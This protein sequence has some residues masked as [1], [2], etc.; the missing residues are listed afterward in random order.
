MTELKCE[1]CGS[2]FM[3]KEYRKNTARF[4]SR[5]CGGKWHASQRFKAKPP[6]IKYCLTCAKP[7]ELRPS[8]YERTKYCSKICMNKGIVKRRNSP[9]T[10]F[11]KGAIPINK[12]ITGTIRIRFR[13]NNKDK[14]RKWIKIAEPNIWILY[15]KYVWQK[16]YGIIPNK[17]LIHHINHNTLDDRIDNLMLLSRAEHM[18]I[19]RK[20]LKPQQDAPH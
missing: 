5:V 4:C 14:P 10:E 2:S 15:A 1:I 19:H 13:M 17:L 7:I 6:M 3:V 20:Q 12:D 16:A 9:A 11:K 18:N 8:K